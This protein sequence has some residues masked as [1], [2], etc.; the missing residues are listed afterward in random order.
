[1]PIV[2]I[3][4]ALF[5]SLGAVPISGDRATHNSRGAPE[6]GSVAPPEGL[7]L[8]PSSPEAAARLFL[9][10]I[11]SS[12]WSACAALIDPDVLSNFNQTV[13]DMRLKDTSGNLLAAG[14][15][16]PDPEVIKALITTVIGIDVRTDARELGPSIADVV[17]G[18]VMATPD[19]TY[20]VYRRRMLAAVIS[21][22]AAFTKLGVLAVRRRADG[23]RIVNAGGDGDFAFLGAA[24]KL[25]VPPTTGGDESASAERVKAEQEVKQA[26]ARWREAKI[27]HDLTTLDRLM[28]TDFVE[29][30]Q[31]GDRFGRQQILALYRSTDL[32][33]GGIALED[34]NIEIVGTTSRA[35]GT[36]L[37]QVKYRGR[38]VGGRLGF[39]EVYVKGTNGWQIQSSRLHHFVVSETVEVPKPSLGSLKVLMLTPLAGS[40]VS[41]DSLIV[42]ELSY[43][44]ETFEPGRF[45]VMAD[46]AT[47]TPGVTTMGHG[48]VEQ[49][50][51]VRPNGRIKLS[52]SLR[53]VW[54]DNDVKRPFEVRFCIGQ[55]IGALGGS[56]SVV[57]TAPAIFKPVATPS[58]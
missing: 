24:G 36:H 49:P 15:D 17:V 8:K 29:V 51:L 10:A 21:P 16:V 6:I 42:A 54:A 45:L 7:Q 3:A 40:E 41:R 46:F 26:M 43:A 55:L 13:K 28:T 25:L 1:M 9:D 38:E 37:E 33:F 27:K 14:T 19:T 32:D 5:I 44:V 39:A 50:V 34:A 2:F 22:S 12:D 53:A 4:F 48:T 31:S 57:C 20:V 23:W 58:K 11:G 18:E 47:T 56:V 52:Y 30:N 35:T